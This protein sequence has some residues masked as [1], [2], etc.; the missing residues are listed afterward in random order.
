MF[1][2]KV[3]DAPELQKFFFCESVP[4]PEA[5]LEKPVTPERLVATIEKILG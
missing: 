2:C 1:R 5:Y 3:G 4:D